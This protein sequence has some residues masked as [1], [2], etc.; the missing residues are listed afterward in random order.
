MR[1]IPGSGKS[2][3]ARNILKTYGENLEPKNHI[4][5]ADDFFYRMVNPDHPEEYNFRP[6][7][8]KEAHKWNYL[9]IQDALINKVDPII[10]D[11][12]HKSLWESK[13]VVLLGIAHSYDIRFEYPTS[14]WWNEIEEY[15][16]NFRQ[17][18]NELRELARLLTEKTTHNIPEHVI[19]RFMA[20][21][22][23][24]EEYTVENVL[25][26]EKPNWAK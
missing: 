10:V 6:N 22:V 1:G 9:R 15:L 16:T 13:D 7:L 23:P 17:N 19:W 4:F 3:T 21:W 14:P 12:T 20:S 11:N 25:E 8:L 24:R 2:F 26:S 18:K 5:A